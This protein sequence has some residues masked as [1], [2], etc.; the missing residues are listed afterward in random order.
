MVDTLE[1]VML[2][3]L[4]LDMCVNRGGQL[5]AWVKSAPAAAVAEVKKL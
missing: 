2:G 3:L 1:F 5:L 4:V